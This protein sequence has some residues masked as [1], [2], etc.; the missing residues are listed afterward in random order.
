[1]S[2]PLSVDTTWTSA[3]NPWVITGDVT[4]ISGRTL[5]IQPGVQVTFAASDSS[6]SGADASRTELIVNGTLSVQ[7]SSTSPVTLTATGAYGVR[8]LG[9]GSAF[10][11]STTIN[12]GRFGVVSAGWTTL[13]SSTIQGA[14]TQCLLVSSGTLSFETGTLRNCAQ[15]LVANGGTTS[16]RDSLVH[17]SGATNQ[18]ALDVFASAQLVHN[19]FTGNL[20][21]A[22]R[23]NIFSGTVNVSDNIITSN[24]Y[25]G[26]YF[27]NALNPTRTVQYNNVWGH[28]TYDYSPATVTPGPGSISANPLFVGAPDFRLTE[29]SPARFA[30]SDGGD[31]G[32]FAHAGHP[33]PT[34]QGVL[35][36][37]KTLSGA[38]TLAG[39]LTVR[40]GVTLTLA[41]GASL[42][43]ATTD[44]LG[45]GIDKGKTELIVDGTLVA[46]GTPEAP[47]TLTATGAYGVRVLSGS[48][49]F[50]STT[51]QAGLYG[52]VSNGSSTFTRSTLQGA[53]STC[54][55]VT[56]GATS[57][58]HGT[59]QN[60]AQALITSGGTT[61]LRYSLVRTSGS[62]ALSQYAIYLQGSARLVHNTLTGNPFGGVQLASFAGTAELSDNVIASNGLYGITAVGSTFPTRTVQYNDVWGHS[63]RDVSTNITLGPGG[64]S[65]NPLFVSAS[66]FHPTENSPA[67]LAASDGTDMGAFAYAGA[68]T[69][70]LQ[71]VLVSDRLL[72]GANTLAG[73]LTVR[74][75]VTLTLAPGASL[76]FAATDGLRSGVDTAKVE[77]IVDGTFAAQGTPEAPVTLTAT[78]AYGVRVQGSATF[79][80]A[81]LNAGLYGVVSSGA[82]VIERTTVQGA[83]TECLRVTGGATH[84]SHGTLR[85]CTQALAATGGTT[86][87]GYSLVHASGSSAGSKHA[88]ALSASA[89]LVHN[90]LTGNSFGA[91]QVASF[92]G[93]VEVYDNLVVSNGS[94]G[95]S[96]ANTTTPTRS[97]H[98]NDVWDH[99]TNYSTASTI[100]PG[101]GSISAN[102]LFVSASDFHPTENSPARLA[103][104][105]GT[106]MGAFAYAGAPTPSLQGVLVSDRLL[107]GANTL[108]GDLTVRP[109]VTLTL[110]PGA[111]LTFA[112]TDGL[113]SGVDTAKVELIVDGTFAAQGTPEAPVTLTAT[114]AYGV[115][116]QGSATFDSATLNAGL[117]GVVSSGAS[118]IERTTVQ[119]AS[120]ECLRV[121]GGTTRFS[122][123][124]LRSCLQALVTTGGTTELHS[125]LVHASGAESGS[126]Y[127][128]V[129]GAPATLVHNTVTG[130]A[131]GG[132]SIKSFTGTVDLHDNI[133]ALNS[134]FGV[135]LENTNTPTRVFHHN[136][137]WGHSI[138]DFGS[139]DLGPG[140]I[141]ANPLLVS[142][143][144]FHP[145]ENS[146]ARLAASDGTDMGAFAYAGAP[147]PS[148]QGV[149]FSDRLLTGANTLAGDLTVRPGVTLTLAP[150]A[151]LTFAAT[152]GLRSG[153]DR[154]RVELIVDGT[155]AAQGTQDAP[156]TLTA[157]GA[158]GVR[159]QGSATLDFTTLHAGLYGAASTGATTF[160]N[161]TLQ[162]ASTQCLL[163][164]GGTT[165]FIQGT[166][167]N[168]RQAIWT[169]SGTIELRYSLVRSSG[170]PGNGVYA[171]EVRGGGSAHVV[172]NTIVDNLYEALNV[173]DDA[174]SISIYDNII[175]SS[176]HRPFY[177]AITPP[178]AIH[179]ND[180]WS[181]GVVWAPSAPLGLGGISANPL[182]VSASDFRLTA[183]SPARLAASDGTDMGAFPY[184]GHPSPGLLGAL[185]SDLTL[186]GANT[187]AGDLTVRPGVTLTLAPG[188]SLTFAATDALGA[189]TDTKKIEL[190]I[191]GHLEAQ[192]TS[193]S[194]VTLT[195]TG[196][197][198]VYVRGSATFDFAT[199]NAG[200]VGVHSTGESTFHRTT[201]QGDTAQCLVVYGG[202]TTF[203]HGTLRNCAQALQSVFNTIT[204]LEHS[205][206]RANGLPA[207]TTYAIALGGQSSLLHNTITGN[208]MGVNVYPFNGDVTLSDN[209][210]TSNG[211]YGLVFSHPSG[212]NR[213]VIHNNVWGHGTANY[214]N[215]TPGPGSLSADPLFVGATDFSLQAT[216]PCR[217]A[218]SDGS[219]MGAFPYVRPLAA[220]VVVTPSAPSLVVQGTQ[221]F[222]AMAYDASN[223]PLP[224]AAITWSAHGAA[225]TI[226]ASGLFTASCTAGTHPGAVTATVD[227]QS[228]S[229]TVT[230]TPGP[231]AMVMLAPATT[232]LSVN[233]TQQFTANVRDGCDNPL[234]LA[235]VSWLVTDGG[236]DIG[237][238]GVFTA[239]TVAGTFTQTITAL[240][241]AL[242]ATA[243][244]TVNPGPTQTVQVTP[245]ST[246]LRVRGAQ[247]FTATATDSWGNTV[248]GTT[249]W[250][251]GSTAVGSIDAEGLFTASGR[252]GAYPGAVT[253]RFDAMSGSADVTL[254]PGDVTRIVVTPAL[255]QLGPRN[256]QPFSAKGEDAEG[257]EVSIAPVWSVLR[258]AGSITP[259]GRFTATSVPGTYPASVLATAHGL[260]GSGSV[261]V[262]P[263]ALHRVVISPQN[264]TVVIQGRI[265]FSAKAYDAFDNELPLTATWEAVNG[266]GTL[267]A[268]GVFTAGL[269]SGTFSNTVR[270]TADGQSASTSVTVSTDS[271]DDGMADEWELAHGFDPNSPGD[272]SLDADDD[273]LSNVAEFEA[274]SDPHD[275]DTDDD[276]VLDGH[277]LAPT[278][279][280]DGDGLP[281]VRDPDSDDDGLFDGTE[282]AVSSPHV[283][284]DVSKEQFV[285]DADPSTRTDPL[286]AD[287][288]GDG[289]KDGEED[290]NHDGR[291]DSSETD[292]NTPDTFCGAPSE[293]GDGEVCQE[294]VCVDAPPVPDEV[295]GEGWGCGG[296]GTSASVMS[297]LLLSLLGLANPRRKG[298]R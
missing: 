40:P 6:G 160:R 292:P 94:Q 14:A 49:T 190:F 211:E 269:H 31:L 20:H 4:I 164:T 183:Y 202:T 204:R 111:S 135:F 59:L 89:A 296:S 76:T 50:D 285:A 119:G 192:G 267:D 8:V 61:E 295:I 219:D 106:D 93:T 189:G 48:A 75:G 104:S 235:P 151:S 229:A 163:V 78:G 98:H 26:V 113:R 108:A 222:T 221:A 125:S 25:H 68:P 10:F 7:G 156:V 244:V 51:L 142:A 116:V 32:A 69:P 132:I 22:L 181:N 246:A 216:S 24:T 140:G 39:D 27:A 242:S 252:A 158:Y 291:L 175:T 83:S 213:S 185:V 38:N 254:A 41:P 210:I 256:E 208:G 18:F 245:A 133:V 53:S 228:A 170:A 191:D 124:T 2:G 11:D 260:A 277:E 146:P 286:N 57:F 294:G 288:D 123:G 273:A 205:L 73:D 209:I 172:H 74:P 141:S 198:G 67:R 214:L 54:L 206:V 147:T 271:D 201:I 237:P 176:G 36:S 278:E 35:F 251:V 130:N 233:D 21:G 258:G 234:P 56:G 180:V 70:S 225:G 91:V 23:I 188:A 107:T 3:G 43:F 247:R 282:M 47:V 215:V 127:A 136:N 58:S 280:S 275:A 110:A 139:S 112:A 167:Q 65:A 120:T 270:V 34:L 184:A 165:R 99:T 159:V 240:S 103:A 171:M 92:A 263:G 17:A 276:G 97:V 287:T 239:G 33:S 283:G 45:S 231:A 64:I 44:G 266:G 1:M 155:F 298:K 195:A 212:P 193:A 174:G 126:R 257:N 55:I 162:G 220:Y 154:A 166:L 173:R 115:R 52:V 95:I 265:T 223:H 281:N 81:T 168:C 137:T 200:I 9:T 15:A 236:G 37:N 293:C 121:T 186:T 250:S 46:Q 42:T 118:V 13:R 194:P 28:S 152:D 96:F 243:S 62:S 259:E 80:S 179:H 297:L 284:T 272:A 157:T 241:G 144:D 88:I 72:T 196:A 100:T 177:S 253:A 90:T 101:P 230:L 182:F 60:C 79:D 261:V 143:S 224:D 279:D 238:D 66:D 148:L 128:M 161:S 122:Q 187:L 264:P 87:L 134:R 290:A 102:P 227:G 255:A 218:A 197:R 226:D 5:T 105:D 262:A 117:Y 169:T 199:L 149:L 145:T 129:L 268:S 12:A 232:T 217:N 248:P 138:S 63:T 274:G 178:G 71:G 114:G 289:R 86:T 203:S 150:G 131:Y 16:L 85:N 207:P 19:T 82:S 249:A 29:Y 30:A 84:F 109:G 77:L 153:V